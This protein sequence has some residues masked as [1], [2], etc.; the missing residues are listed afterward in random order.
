MY[1]GKSD[2]GREIRLWYDYCGWIQGWAGWFR[3]GIAEVGEMA[4]GPRTG[5]SVG[6]VVPFVAVASAPS[7]SAALVSP[8]VLH[9]RERRRRGEITT[10]EWDSYLALGSTVRVG[11]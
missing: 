8:L 6:S 3:W 4:S 11:P 5:H 1:P 10:V 9:G 7:G 2:V